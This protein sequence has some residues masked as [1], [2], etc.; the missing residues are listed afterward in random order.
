MLRGL[1]FLLSRWECIYQP[2]PLTTKPHEHWMPTG[3]WESGNR[4]LGEK[5][6][7]PPQ[8]SGP[9]KLEDLKKM[10]KSLPQVPS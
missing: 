3:R 1:S 8:V 7:S 5:E 6:E 9:I 10:K 4:I 2:H